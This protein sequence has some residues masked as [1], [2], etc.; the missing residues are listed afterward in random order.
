MAPHPIIRTIIDGYYT[1]EKDKNNPFYHQFATSW[2][3]LRHDLEENKGYENKMSFY[4]ML[5]AANKN[6]MKLYERCD[7]ARFYVEQTVKEFV[8]E[9]NKFKIHIDAERRGI[10]LELIRVWEAVLQTYNY[11]ETTNYTN[12]L[13]LKHDL[14]DV[15]IDHECPTMDT[16]II[17]RA[18]E[19]ERNIM[20]LAHLY[21][22][23]LGLSKAIRYAQV[24]GRL[25]EADEYL[26][27]GAY[28][29]IDI[30]WLPPIYRSLKNL[31]IYG[32]LVD[33]A[34]KIRFLTLNNN[35]R[36]NHRECYDI[37]KQELKELGFNPEEILP[38]EAKSLS[39]RARRYSKARLGNLQ[40]VTRNDSRQASMS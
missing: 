21:S 33:T 34:V 4:M 3:R 16:L 10:I 40:Q 6:S 38:E 37:I 7:S 28:P 19:I 1:F 24:N 13:Y 29:D 39:D 31:L 22:T 5:E 32:H 30:D 25:I 23:F 2:E 20:K 9:L 26:E 8:K 12:M 18:I 17:T 35:E 11:C 14:R 27:T 36:Y 15:K